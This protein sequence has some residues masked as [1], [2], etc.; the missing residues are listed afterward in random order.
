MKLR[1]LESP[2]AGEDNLNEGDREVLRVAWVGNRPVMSADV[3]KTGP[4][5]WGILAHDIIWAASK[6]IADALGVEPQK[7]YEIGLAGFIQEMEKD[8]AELE[9]Q[10]TDN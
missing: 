10:R 9:S 4:A 3:G 6:T 7:A 5:F 8:K 1:E 2:L